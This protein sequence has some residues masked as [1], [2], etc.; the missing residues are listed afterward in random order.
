MGKRETLILWREKLIQKLRQ[1][2]TPES[3]LERRADEMMAP[4]LAAQKIVE[5]R[6]QKATRRMRA[7]GWSDDKI[8]QAL[9]ELAFRRSDRFM[10]AAGGPDEHDYSNDQTL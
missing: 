5:A 9:V 6:D 1:R 8:A 4:I 10:Q 7:R 2:G 3:D